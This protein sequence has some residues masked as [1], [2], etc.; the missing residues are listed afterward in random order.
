MNNTVRIKFDKFYSE[1]SRAYLISIYNQEVWLPK[2]MCRSF[3]TNK[4]LGGNVVI[5]EWLYK[6]KFGCEPSDEM[7]E[8]I[9]EHH[10]PEKMQPVENNLIKELDR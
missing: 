10:T 4:K 3:I 2:K 6:E 8:T 9:V 1:T 7:Y 5:P